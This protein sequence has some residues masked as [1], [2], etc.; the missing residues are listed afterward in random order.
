MTTFLYE[1][2]KYYNQEILFEM[3]FNSKNYK[4]EILEVVKQI[5][6][7]RGL[8]EIF[9]KELDEINKK[10][11]EEEEQYDEKIE[12]KANYY[13][14]VV[15]FRNDGN[16]FQIRIADIPRF[17]AALNEQ[18]IEFFRE[19]KHIGI[20]LDTYPTQTYFFRNKDIQQVERITKELELN[21]APYAD[22]SPF[23]RFEII[24]I[25]IVVFAILLL[26]CAPIRF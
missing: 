5:I 6:A 13:K 4:P 17:E 21:T 15:E 25:I 2:F 26:I 14:N 19:D 11:K 9:E 1:K 22:I 20:Q 7:E 18:E 10:R 3:G 16:S 24:V 8:T 12:E 23:I